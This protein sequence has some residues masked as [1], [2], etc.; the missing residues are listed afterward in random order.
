MAEWMLTDEEILKVTNTL[1]AAIGFQADFASEGQR[2]IAQ[3]QAK[4][5]VEWLEERNEK[6]T[7]LAISSNEWRELR[8]QVGL[9]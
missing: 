1:D 7:C 8:R 2:E 3:A 6:L 4:K 9:E 5:L